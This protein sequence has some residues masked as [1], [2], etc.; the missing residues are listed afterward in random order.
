MENLDE[1]LV[2]DIEVYAQLL[3]KTDLV[4]L[5]TRILNQF[6][7]E[8]RNEEFIRL[9]DFSGHTLIST[10]MSAWPKVDPIQSAAGV[11]KNSTEPVLAT[12]DSPDSDYQARMVSAVIGPNTIMQIAES[13]E[14]V[15]PA[16]FTDVRNYNQDEIA[17][18]MPEDQ[19]YKD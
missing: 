3:Q 13:L 17:L 4:H 16:I 5:K 6:E 7:A 15:D 19:V 2:D 14:D 8:D 10:D 12:I 18:K 1:E 11:N 9:V